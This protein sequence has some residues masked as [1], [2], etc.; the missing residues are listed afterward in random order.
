LHNPE[1]TMLEWY[2]PG[3]THRDLMIEM[4][5]LLRR[6]LNC[7]VAK[8]E[9]YG[10]LFLRFCEIDP[11]NTNVEELKAC[12]KKQ[13]LDMHGDKEPSLTFWLQLLMSEVIEPHLGCDQRPTFVTDFPVEQAALA[14][15]NP[16][17][18]AVAERFEVYWRGMELAN[19]FHELCDAEEQRRRFEENNRV[20]REQGL[21][22]MAMDENFLAALV[23]G[24][25]ACAG[26]ALG[27]DR[28]VMAALG[29]DTISDVIAFP[30]DRA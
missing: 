27:V 3:F 29:C 11:Y 7:E 15:I 30:A 14:K 19:G 26:V 6:I 17:P 12:A 18:P 20:R 13:G 8:I 9:S 28:L 4:D 23:H 25:P 22:E 24:L 16:G 5:G 1:F 2:R 10:D 21:P